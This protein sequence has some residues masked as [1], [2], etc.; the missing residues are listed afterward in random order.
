MRHKPAAFLA[1]HPFRAVSA[2]NKAGE[3]VRLLF[4][5]ASI[6]E[7][8]RDYT[9]LVFYG[10][11]GYDFTAVGIVKHFDSAKAITFEDERAAFS[12]FQTSRPKFDLII[13]IEFA[14]GRKPDRYI[15]MTIAAS[16]SQKGKFAGFRKEFRSHD[17]LVDWVD[18]ITF[19]K[20]HPAN[21]WPDNSSFH[22]F[23]HNIPGYRF[24]L[25]EEGAE[26]LVRDPDEP[27]AGPEQGVIV[28]NVDNP[29]I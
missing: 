20:E 17:P 23:V 16:G 3:Q 5:A 24:T 14:K 25:D 21:Y 29:V 11:D 6:L 4:D 27:V 15:G 9:S 1:A 8:L 22:E 10:D 19:T 18:M 2:H 13:E 26:V 7:S 28:K 12:K